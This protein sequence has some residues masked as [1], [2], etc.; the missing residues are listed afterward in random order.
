MK[1]YKPMW[2]QL[3]ILVPVMIGM[4]LVEQLDPMPGISSEFVDLGVVVLTFGM[5][6]AWMRINS[7]LIE[8]DEMEKDESLCDLRI[9]IYDPQADTTND[10]EESNL[11]MPPVSPH[12]ANPIPVERRKEREDIEK[13]S[14]N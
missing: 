13:W 2:W 14:L 5:M 6:L 12:S 1:Q 10:V 4:I 7:G 3:Y 8:S 11:W 9:T